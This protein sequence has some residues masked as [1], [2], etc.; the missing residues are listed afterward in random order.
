LQRLLPRAHPETLLFKR[1]IPQGG[2]RRAPGWTLECIKGNGLNFFLTPRQLQDFLTV[3]DPITHP[4]TGGM[5]YPTRGA[6]LKHMANCLRKIIG[7]RRAP[8]FVVY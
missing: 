8:R 4:A 2:I 6:Y 1:D 3:L 5:K 7:V